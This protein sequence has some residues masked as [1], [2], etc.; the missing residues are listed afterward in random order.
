MA[1]A[2]TCYCRLYRRSNVTIPN[3][4]ET[5]VPFDFAEYDTTGSMWQRSGGIMA[6]FTGIYVARSNGAF[7]LDTTGVRYLHLRVNLR[8]VAIQSVPAASAQ[9]AGVGISIGTDV[10]LNAGDL[11]SVY[12]F[13]NSGAGL[14]FFPN[15]PFY[16]MLSL[17]GRTTP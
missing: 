10:S 5:L 8:S 4:V 15:P 14:I 2:Q 16:P 7:A 12:A 1:D 13:Q 6:P 17:R 3:N 11:V 9:A